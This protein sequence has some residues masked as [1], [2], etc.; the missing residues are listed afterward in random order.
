MKKAGI[1][2][3]AV[4]VVLTLL[5]AGPIDYGSPARAAVTPR[6]LLVLAFSPGEN[7]RDM[8]VSDINSAVQ[9]LWDYGFEV[10]LLDAWGQSG[11]VAE[12]PHHQLHEHLDDQSFNLVIYYG[13]GSSSDWAFCLP[14]DSAWASQSQTAQGWDEYREFGDYRAHWREEIKLA[15]DALVVMRHTCYSHGLEAGDMNS[16]ARLLVEE[17][18]LLRINQ[19]SYT[20]LYPYCGARSYT[21]IANVGATS[22]YLKNLF[23]NYDR[24]I[25]E[26]TV[27]D[28]SDSHQPGDGY[29]LLTGAHPYLSGQGTVYRKNRFPGTSNLAVWSQ[30]AWA[31]DPTLSMQR[32]CGCVPG[33]KNGDGDNVD[34]GEPCFP[35]DERDVFASEDTSYN[36]FPFLCLANPNPA[37]TWAE[38]TFYDEGGNT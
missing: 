18:V 38:I 11:L 5:S 32:V 3:I 2:M 21:A 4:A 15:S 35:H 36:F 33:D 29:R 28:Y 26:L 37:D 8:S 12:Y 10:T 22:S 7:L 17:E 25:G 23:T 31:G 6:A 16:G 34:L 24:S 20:F 13:H 30:P 1:I 19:Y 27:P 9:L 14:Q